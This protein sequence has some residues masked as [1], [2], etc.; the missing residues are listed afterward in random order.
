VSEPAHVVVVGGGITGLTAA[1]RLACDRRVRLTLLEAEQRFGGRVRTEVFAGRPLDVGAEAMLARVPQ[2]AALCRQLGL[3][4]RLVSPATDRPFVWTRG[5]LRPLPPRLLA[6]LP[7]GAGALMRSGILSPAGLVRAG[8]DLA[9]PSRRLQRDTTIGYVV[10]RRLGR[11]VH[12]R[13]VDPLL[14]GIH[15]GSCDEL[16]VQAVAPM[17]EQALA[18]GRG[19]VRGLRRLA[20]AG[21][22][23]GAHEPD[24][25]TSQPPMFIGLTGGLG[26]LVEA[27]RDAL[28]QASAA[29]QTVDLRCGA[30]VEAVEPA[31]SGRVRVFLS[32]PEPEII[33]DAVLLATPAFETARMVEAPS[34][35]AAASLRGIGYA[36]VA[37]ILL[38]YPAAALSAPLAGSG[39]LVPRT[40]GRMLTACTWSSAKWAHLSGESVVLKASVGNFEDASALELDDETLVHRVHAELHEAMA[41]G[42]EPLQGHV[43]RFERSLPQ[44]RVGHV[45]LVDTIES[46][47]AGL[48][49]VRVAGAAYRGVGVASCVRAAQAVADD[50]V[51]KVVRKHPATI[52]T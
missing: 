35:D 39:F 21:R 26:G 7:G 42:G 4:D 43:S 19:L 29:G 17:L 40:E 51:A 25:R 18:S 37:T 49:G 5:R 13:L 6:G 50:W 27:L 1:H 9:V 24:R 52:T 14:G 15:A 32:G 41:L 20:R 2:A 31:D 12:E 3:G 45:A 44:Y 47:L 23:A 34:P 46:Q 16:S 11:E 48:G 8:L 33:A 10:R 22:E 28:I 38:E 30:T 36:S